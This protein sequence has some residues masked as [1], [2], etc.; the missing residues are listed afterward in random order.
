M[1]KGDLPY[2]MQMAAGLNP[3]STIL[4]GAM[5]DGKLHFKVTESVGVDRSVANCPM[6]SATAT[7]F[8]TGIAFDWKEDGDCGGGQMVLNRG[9]IR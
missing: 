1:K 7:P 3:A 6:T 9:A 8:A 2:V 4:T 5:E